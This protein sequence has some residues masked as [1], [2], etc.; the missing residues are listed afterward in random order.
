M[1]GGEQNSNSS[2]NDPSSANGSDDTAGKPPAGRQRNIPATFEGIQVNFCK[3]PGCD[4]FGVPP[5]LVQTF[6]GGRGNKGTGPD[7]Y[8]VTSGGD[9]ASA[10]YCHRCEKTSRLKSNKAVHEE[11]RRQASFLFLPLPVRCPD[12]GCPNHAIAPTRERFSR[13]GR[14][15]GDSLRFRCRACGKTF[16]VAGPTVRQ[17]RTD[18]NA[19]ILR[20]LVNKTPLSRLVE[21]EGV[22]FP[23]LYG[24]IAFLYRQCALFAASR[25]ARLPAM[26]LGERWL[27]TDRQDYLVNW[28]SRSARRTIQLTAVTTADQASGY[29]FGLQPN[30]DPDLTPEDV[31]AG[32]E[33]SGDAA[34]PPHMRDWARVWT[35]A[36]YRTSVV[37]SAA[38]A[39][40][41]G[42]QGRSGQRGTARDD[43]EAPEGLTPAQQLPAQGAQVHAE[44]LVH[45]HFRLLRHLLG[46][47]TR[48]NFSIDEDAGLVTG[49]LGAFADWVRE[50]RAE[51]VQLRVRKEI[52]IDERRRLLEEARRQFRQE[53]RRFR[54][55]DEEEVKVALLAERVARVRAESPLAVRRLQAAWVANPLPDTAEP[56]KLFRFITDAG[57]MNDEEVAAV[58]L[59]STLWP[60]DK[61]FN[62]LRRRVAMFERPV[63]S[64]RRAGRVWH[65][66]APY[67][68]SMVGRL[69]EIFRVWHN[70]LCLG[71][72]H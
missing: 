4:N 36:D 13:Y 72:E 59:R 9:G 50:G 12:E 29:V 26:A 69:L 45:G 53:Q 7:G 42:G 27:S 44:Y 23:T 10:V 64:V 25:E 40:R 18:V 70:W 47:A 49:V 33:A 6:R 11:F 5:A 30:F 54:G 46:G 21:L 8:R 3:T 32:W 35:V 55:L 1:A 14:T 67:D 28:G 2:P 24:K 57:H 68:P 71:V 48:L 52:V 56:E 15:K 62:M 60:V 31:E 37:R 58:L 51:V 43:L 20:H 38:E 41:N 17:R 65:L 19:S 66:Y 61:V 22:S 39:A 16:S 63:R 34:K